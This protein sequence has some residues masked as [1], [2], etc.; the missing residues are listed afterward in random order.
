MTAFWP[1]TAARVAELVGGRCIGDGGARAGRAVVDTRAGVHRGDLFFG[2]VGDHFDGGRYVE[3][4]WAAGATVAVT[5]R[6]DVTPPDG[7]AAVVVANPLAA[8]QA[9]ATAARASFA[10]RV[11]AITGSN[12]KTTVKD[13]AVAALGGSARVDASPGS[14]NSQVGV[15]LTLLGLDPAA[16]VAIVECGISQPGEMTRLERMVRPDAGIFVNVGD[17]HA[18]GLGARTVTAAEKATLFRRV[19]DDG[20]V[21]VPAD[22]ALA[23]DA[24]EAV[25][26]P[27]RPVRFTRPTPTTLAVPRVG[28]IDIPAAIAE[29]AVLTMDAALA[30]ALAALEGATPEAISA[31]LARWRPAPMRLEIGTTP[32][33]VLL[34]NDAYTA[35]PVSVD[36]ALATLAREQSGAGATIAV[37]GGMAQLGER[38]AGAHAAVGAQVVAH[39]IDRLIGVG[40]GGAEIVD[41]AIA[42]GLAPDRTCAVA[43]VRAAVDV[44]E[45][46]TKSGDRVLLKASRPERLERIAEWLFDGFA[47]TRAWIDLSR[48]VENLRVARRRVGRDVAV[49]AMIK[50]FG[51]GL[52]AVRL[53]RVLERAGIDAFGVAFADEGVALRDAGVTAPIL[54]QNVLPGDVARLVRHGLVA[55][56]AADWQIG[57]LAD[58]GERQGRVVGVHLKV[59]T[60]MGR[61][62]FLPDELEP[63]TRRVLASEWLALDGVMTHLASADDPDADAYTRAQLDAFDA[64]VAVVRACGARPTHVHACNSAGLV[65]FGAH[66]H[67]L[68]RT[69]IGL[70]G[71]GSDPDQRPVLR[72]VTRVVSVRTLPPGHPVGYGSSWRVG[73]T[74]RR[75]AV[76]AIGY[77][78]GYPRALS[79]RGVLQVHGTDCPVVGRVCMDVTMIDVTDVPVDVLPGDEVVVIGTE[80]G[81]PT[82]EAIAEA[83]GTIPYEVLTHLSPRVRRIFVADIDGAPTPPTS[84]RPPR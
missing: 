23:R 67:T 26:A 57:A 11:V 17:A 64:A 3:A 72:L 52:D 82:L 4:A 5:A 1:L 39:G 80:P 8:L 19:P 42:A 73:A 45:A 12:G 6:A 79:N 54:V 75:I 25:G 27:E 51:Y 44:L 9:L 22:E 41:A 76:V 7:A 20:V 50:S 21:F 77:N 47:P 16:S 49:M 55:E 32:R 83:W 34:L 33:G 70:F 37:L 62:G 53:A 66:G 2:L 24:L 38:R 71:Y 43:D 10:G 31:G 30:V 36:A 28:T 13:L 58:E 84:G 40:E 46:T 60:G 68:V 65:R 35:D 56:L 81:E 59:E 69:G 48:V 15:A 18:A 61:S 14:W 78:D 74:P 63:A 29:S